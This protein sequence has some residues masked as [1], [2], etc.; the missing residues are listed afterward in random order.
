MELLQN[1]LIFLLVFSLVG[2]LFG[3]FYGLNSFRK[4]ICLS[5]SYFSLV[6]I[7][8][9]FAKNTQQYAI[10]F[11]LITTIFILFS[12]TLVVGLGIISNITKLNNQKSAKR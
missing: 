8:I 2:G 3:L 10:L 6:V 1:I 12:I 4:I 9:I 5:I 7:L 11:T